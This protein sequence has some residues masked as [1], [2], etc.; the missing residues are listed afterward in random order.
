MIQK[1]YIEVR[2]AAGG[3]EAKIWA[4]DLLRMYLRYATKVGW[5]FS[6]IDENTAVLIGENVFDLL[7][8]ESG[9]H[10]VQ[11][12]PAT[13]KRGRIHTSTAS[14]VILP[15]IKESDININPAEVEWQF[16]RAST[17][18][19]QNVQKVSTA[20]RL[21]HKPTQ[22]V[23]TSEQERFQEQNRNIALELLRAKLW[24]RAEEKKEKE[25]A[26]YRSAI[27]RGMRAEKIRTYN[28]P[29]DRVTDHRI[30]KKF[31]NLEAIVDGNLDKIIK[32]LTE[33]LK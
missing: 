15:E 18:G 12:V 4:S 24:E 30:N 22:I 21:I 13:E 19:G 29:Q 8:H 25:I 7:K 1:A 14:V 3:D 20:V 33:K 6:Q 27:G 5:K 10:R 28:Y 32:T 9:V 17:Q 26:G 23:V 16:Y 2:A 31:G 11:R